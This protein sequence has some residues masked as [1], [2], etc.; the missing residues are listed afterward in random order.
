MGEYADEAIDQALMVHYGFTSWGEELYPDGDDELEIE[1]Y[2]TPIT[3]RTCRYCGMKGLRWIFNS[4]GK[5]RLYDMKGG[6][7]SCLEYRVARVL[8]THL[9][10]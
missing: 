8:S 5:W 10:D 3:Y 9:P 7:H 1:R 4:E 2:E 6:A